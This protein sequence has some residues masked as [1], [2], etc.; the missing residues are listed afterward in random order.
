MVIELL[1][2]SLEDLFVKLGNRMSEKSVLMI[3]DQML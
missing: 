1:S 3:A 2:S